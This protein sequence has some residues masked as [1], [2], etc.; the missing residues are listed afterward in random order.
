[1]YRASRFVRRNR[2]A[3]V[4]ASALVVALLG[5][6]GAVLWQ[7]QET[8]REA[9]R[10][11]ATLDYV[12]GMFETI[13]PVALE[14]GEIRSA[15]LVAPGLE[16]AAALED[17][18]LVQ[19]SLLAGLGRLSVS[20]GLF[21]TADSV[22][23][24]SVEVRRRV[25]GPD[26][27]DLAEPLTWLVRSR[28]AERRYDDAFEA[29]F[30][31]V[32]LLGSARDPDALA[33]AQ[34]ALAQVHYR[35]RE[36]PEAAALYRSALGHARQPETEMEATLGLATQ[37]VEADSLE[38]ALP[39][40][41]QATD[42]ATRSFGPTDPRTA[43]ALYEYADAVQASGDL[44]GAER[45][46]EQALEVYERAYGSGDYRT[47][48]S[49]YTLAN[50]LHESDL[51]DAERFYR[52]ALEAYNASTLDSDHLWR[53]YVRVAL[54]GLLLE[55]DRPAEAL[56]LLETGAD[57][58]AEAF[59]DED[60]STL[61]AQTNRAKALIQMGRA[62]QGLPILRAVDGALER[63]AP[64][65]PLRTTVLDALSGALRTLGRHRE[66]SAV[67]QKRAQLA[68]LEDE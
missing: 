20:L 11:N 60:A 67:A 32:R 1:G 46:H 16:R 15:D 65:D 5:G 12:L 48:R 57:A 18:P 63:E 28:T 4:G 58:F 61:S 13:D 55:T 31:A 30:E 3:V 24:R 51:E 23:S 10:A 27:A 2:V 17:Q 41:Q 33:R 59:G 35:R 42:L 54:G 45:V 64:K 21:T 37:L 62:A 39:L 44:E 29:G 14:G 22:L 68:S 43:D 40:F 66:A 6:T 36:D 7:A 8:A 53:E 34:I 47:A 9:E 52:S 26:H 56:P 49:L 25:Q 38:A 50:L 19:A